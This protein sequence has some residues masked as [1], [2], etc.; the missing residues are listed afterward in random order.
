MSVDKLY[1]FLQISKFAYNNSSITAT[2][3]FVYMYMSNHHPRWVSL[4]ILEVPSNSRA[5]KS[6]IHPNYERL[7]RR[8]QIIYEIPKQH[9][10]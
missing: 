1:K 10:K 2:P 7:K 4:E 5:K 6:W 3:F 9:A 8:D